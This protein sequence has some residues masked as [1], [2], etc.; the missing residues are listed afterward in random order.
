MIYIFSQKRMLFVR[1]IETI[2]LKD[3]DG[4]EKI[5]RMMNEMHNSPPKDIGVWDVL[6]ITRTDMAKNRR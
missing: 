1:W 2:T 6:V 3:M 4:A 5:Q